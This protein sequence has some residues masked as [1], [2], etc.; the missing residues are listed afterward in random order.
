MPITGNAKCQVVFN[1]K[2]DLTRHLIRGH[3]MDKEEAQRLAKGGV[4]AVTIDEYTNLQE[5]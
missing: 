2:L 3:K 5:L 1:R 4:L